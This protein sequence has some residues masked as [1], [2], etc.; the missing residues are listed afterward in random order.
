[1][2]NFKNAI[3]CLVAAAIL[4]SFV[5][6][7][8][9][10]EMNVYFAVDSSEDFD[11]I[12]S[13]ARD[14]TGAYYTFDD[15]IGEGIKVVYVFAHMK[16]YAKQPETI[17][18]YLSEFTPGVFTTFVFFTDREPCDAERHS[19]MYGE[20]GAFEEIRDY[21]KYPYVQLYGDWHIDTH[22]T[23]ED[24]SLVTFSVRGEGEEIYYYTYYDGAPLLEMCGCAELSE[25][26]VQLLFDNLVFVEK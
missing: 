9:E 19:V 26:D 5:G 21:D 23:V 6:C 11:R 16:A 12:W 4:L 15:D 3:V 2:K 18:E 1:M 17:D 10:Q 25:A 24:S 20:L 14:G 8:P 7:Y 13:E 22:V